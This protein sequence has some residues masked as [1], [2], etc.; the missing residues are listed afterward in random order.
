MS[1]NGNVTDVSLGT[2]A[3]AA[4]LPGGIM[5]GYIAALLF[6]VALIVQL[7]GANIGHHVDFDTFIAAGLL[8]LALHLAGAGSGWGKRR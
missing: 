8:A 7:A 5:L 4:E 1:C 3:M 2:D 6:L